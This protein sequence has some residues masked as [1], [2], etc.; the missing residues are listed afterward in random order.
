M[1]ERARVV[2][3]KIA[4]YPFP[5]QLDVNNVKKPVEVVYLAVTGAIIKLHAHMVFVGEIYPLQFELP[6]STHTIA[7]QARVLKTYD[8]VIDPR[9]QKVER[10]AELHFHNLK[11]EHKARVASF[12]KAIGQRK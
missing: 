8:R 9:E 1:S 3:K 2:K 5:A 7:T 4:P 6:L 11:S 10:M 12:V